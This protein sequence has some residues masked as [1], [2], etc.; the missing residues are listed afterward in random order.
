MKRYLILL[1]LF[2]INL[3]GQY[4]QTPTHYDAEHTSQHIIKGHLKMF[5]SDSIKYTVEKKTE[6][7]ITDCCIDPQIAKT[8]L[9]KVFKK[10]NPELSGRTNGGYLFTIAVINPKDDTKIVNYVTFHVDAWTQ[11]IVEIEVL[12]GE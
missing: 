8:R 12:L 3:L 10:G 6:R 7:Y 1:L 5:C 9:D 4:I 2:P 11:K